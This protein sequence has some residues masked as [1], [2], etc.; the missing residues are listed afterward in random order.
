MSLTILSTGN[1]LGHLR[2]IA[3]THD[4]LRQ[5]PELIGTLAQQVV[6][7]VWW[8]HH[9]G[10]VNTHPSWASHLP[11]LEDIVQDLAATIGDRG[12]PCQGDEVISTLQH[13]WT[14]RDGGYSCT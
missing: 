10:L 2:R 13:F 12:R 8:R 1:R 14:S 4:I 9:G 5:H 6:Y 7:S 3:E 11:L